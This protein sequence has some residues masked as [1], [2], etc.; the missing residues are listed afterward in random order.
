VK[1]KVFGCE[2]GGSLNVNA[3]CASVTEQRVCMCCAS[4]NANGAIIYYLCLIL[5][6]QSNS[7]TMVYTNVFVV[8]LKLHAKQ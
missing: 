3:L 1:L 7:H 6:N 2:S 4:L 5:S 8:D